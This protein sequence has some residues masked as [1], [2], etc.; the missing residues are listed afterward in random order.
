MDEKIAERIALQWSTKGMKVDWLALETI[1]RDILRGYRGAAE[2]CPSHQP[3]AARIA[4]GRID[5]ALGAWTRRGQE[6]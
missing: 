4:L 3:E 5:E 2:V 6:L 1:L